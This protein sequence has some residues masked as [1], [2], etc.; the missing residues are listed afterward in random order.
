MIY[1]EFWVISCGVNFMWTHC[2]SVVIVL[3]LFDDQTPQ[4]KAQIER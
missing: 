1:I 2:M 3:N 4:N